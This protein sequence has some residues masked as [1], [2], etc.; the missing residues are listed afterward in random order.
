MPDGM[1][2]NRQ[3]LTQRQLDQAAA[4]FDGLSPAAARRVA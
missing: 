2:D 1:N 3:G 4:I